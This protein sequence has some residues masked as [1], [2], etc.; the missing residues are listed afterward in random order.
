MEGRYFFYLTYI[1]LQPSVVVRKFSPDD[2]AGYSEE[3]L[4][5]DPGSSC[6]TVQPE[7]FGSDKDVILRVTTSSLV[8]ISRIVEYSLKT[9]D[10]FGF[11]GVS[12]PQGFSFQKLMLADQGFV[13]AFAYTRGGGELG[14][15]WHER[16]RLL[17]RKVALAD[18]ITCMDEVVR[19]GYTSRHRLALESS[20]A[21]GTAVIALA[22]MAP[23]AFR[24]GLAHM[25]YTD[26]LGSFL[27]GKPSDWAEFGNPKNA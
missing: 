21:G 20:S 22:N 25:P 13:L 23:G 3:W 8:E 1:K 19:L 7:L 5:V 12:S 24:V 2:S 16:G 15:S 17:N 27:E 9:R 26:L 14:E 4:V 18:L 11:Y 10:S 6:G